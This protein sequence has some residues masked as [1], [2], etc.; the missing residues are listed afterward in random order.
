MN[1]DMNETDG[2]ILDRLHAILVERKSNP[3]EFSYTTK[4]LRKGKARIAKKLGEE[5]VETVI[6]GVKGDRDHLVSESA[7]LL[8]FL[9]LLW[10]ANDVAPEAVWAELARR[11]GERK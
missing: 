7:D 6:E 4:I 10:V 1:E 2:H 3:S 11:R 5:A 9:T 8:Y